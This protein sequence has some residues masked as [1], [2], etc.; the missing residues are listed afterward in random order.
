MQGV[1]RAMRRFF[2]GEVYPKGVMITK[3][4]SC[5][6]NNRGWGLPERGKEDEIPGREMRKN[7]RGRGYA[8]E[9]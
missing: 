7:L 4:G 2:F 8:E 3:F 6:K 5:C 1:G 9:G